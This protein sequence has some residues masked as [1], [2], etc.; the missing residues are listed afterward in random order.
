MLARASKTLPDA[1]RGYDPDEILD[2][3]LCLK[4]GKLLLIEALHDRLI[5]VCLLC[6][7]RDGRLIADW[8]SVVSAGI[9]QTHP[10]V[11]LFRIHIIR[12]RSGGAYVEYASAGGGGFAKV[13]ESAIAIPYR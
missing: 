8:H 9:S 6:Q 1:S 5:R 2:A 7:S 13:P 4:Y 10:P 3:G 11:A 12:F